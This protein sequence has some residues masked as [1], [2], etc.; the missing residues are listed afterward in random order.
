LSPLANAGE[1][2]K[3]ENICPEH[4]QAVGHKGSTESVEGGH[5]GW[6]NNSPAI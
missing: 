6:I 1:W 4:G 3:A 5:A 2:W